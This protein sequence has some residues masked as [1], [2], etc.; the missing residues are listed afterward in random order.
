LRS[1]GDKD[2]QSYVGRKN[3]IRKKRSWRY[4]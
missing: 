1:N 4:N 3:E 2:A